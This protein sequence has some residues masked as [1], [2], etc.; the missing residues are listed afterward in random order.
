MFKKERTAVNI[1]W[2]RRDLR[3][4]DN[5]A[6]YHAL[7]TRENVLPLFIFNPDILEGIEFSPSERFNFI[8]KTLLEVKGKLEKIGS[9]L[10][11]KFGKPTDVFKNLLSQYHIC[12]VYTNRDYE[13]YS[14][15][16]DLYVERFL[17]INKI[18]FF[19]Y[20]DHVIFEKDELVKP[21]GKPYTV[22]TA[23][24]NKFIEKFNN[25]MVHSLDTAPYF[26]NFI[27][28]KP[29]SIPTCEEL[30]FTKQDITFPPKKLSQRLL[31]DYSSLKDYPSKNA[32]SKLSVHLRFGTVSIRKITAMAALHSSSFF[33]E[34]IWRNF[35]CQILWF[36]PHVATRA[37]KPSYD[38][39]I[40][41]NN[42]DH[43]EAWCKGK[44][45]YPFVDAG[46]RELNETGFMHNRLRMVTASF[47]CKQLL[48]DWRW[49]EAYFARK[50]LD[51]DLASNNGGWQWCAGTGCDATPYFRIFNPEL[52]AKKFD[53]DFEYIYKWVPEYGT[54][55][56][57]LPIIDLKFARD[58][59]LQRYSQA[60][61]LEIR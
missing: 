36:Y 10:V 52:Q 17:K 47:L 57:P 14:T 28:T 20:K 16:Q 9:S 24:K 43:F 46:M 45:G 11:V 3:L 41:E 18:D 40:W 8:Y 37:F 22:F 23:Y 59:A 49:G 30:G 60:L 50:L 13:P 26:H 4:D 54:A 48:I 27:R 7:K 19:S 15:Y 1:F 61:G 56:Y 42:Q 38:N 2:F 5:T 51:Y 33:S 55:D 21:D 34:L 58:R 6:L 39:I 53:T 44:T 12:S 31:E 35:F 32:T 25:E 29:F